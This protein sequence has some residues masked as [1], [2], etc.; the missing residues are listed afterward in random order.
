MN[1][2]DSP[3]L[4]RY[5]EA[6]TSDLAPLVSAGAGQVTGQTDDVPA[7]LTEVGL[8]LSTSVRESWHLGLIE[9]AASGAVPVVRDWP[10]FADMPRGARSLFPGSWVVSSP[11]EAAERILAVNESAET[12]LKAGHEASEQ[13]IS[14][15]D[16]QTVAPH[17]DRLLITRSAE[18]P[19]Q[20]AVRTTAE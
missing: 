6:F 8:I 17:F 7:A 2:A 10:F 20:R 15:W 16:W 3:A 1:P 11:A 13:A 19:A 12:W 14:T 4:A 18:I 5:H 9:G